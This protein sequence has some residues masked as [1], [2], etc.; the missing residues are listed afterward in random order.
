MSDGLQLV[1]KALEVIHSPQSSNADRL[2]AQ[3]H[4]DQLS[5][6]RNAACYFG[7]ELAKQD[8]DIVRHFGLNLLSNSITKEWHNFSTA[9]RDQI[10]QWVLMLCQ[11]C[12]RETGETHYI[13]EKLA[14]LLNDIAKREWLLTWGDFDGTLQRLWQT[15]HTTRLVCLKTLN[16]LIEDVFLHDDPI[17]ALRSPILSAGVM[18]LMAPADVVAEFYANNPTSLVHGI[19]QKPGSKGWL[20]VLVEQLLQDSEDQAL[21]ILQ[22][23]RSALGWIITKAI[24]VSNTMSAVCQALMNPNV[25]ISTCAVD[26]LYVLLTRP[27][28]PHDDFMQEI[29]TLYKPESLQ[30]L[31]EVWRRTAGSLQFRHLDNAGTLQNEEAYTLLKKLSETIVALACFKFGSSR[32]KK[33]EEIELAHVLDLVL[34]T[35][36]HKSLI[37]SGM[38]H[39]FWCSLLRDEKLSNHPDVLSRFPQMLQIGTQRL[40]RFDDAKTI[41]LAHSE[42][43]MFLDIDMESPLELHEFCINYRRFVYDIVRM[44]VYKRPRDALL[45]VREQVKHFF[46]EEYADTNVGSFCT[47]T[48]PMYL[49]VDAK[50]TMIEAAIQGIIRWQD[51][52]VP[53]TNPM[54]DLNGDATPEARAAAYMELQ[55]MKRAEVA[56]TREIVVAWCA[57]LIELNIQ[58]PLMLGRH[59]SVLVAFASFLDDRSDLLFR[60]LEK[61]IQTITHFYPIDVAETTMVSIRELRGR[62]GTDI[63]R[64]ASALPDQLWTIY[65]QLEATVDKILSAEHVSENDQTTFNAL[66]LIIS[67]RASATEPTEKQAHFE[68][69][70]NKVCSAWDN[71]E[72]TGALANFES[73]AQV[74]QVE[75]VTMYFQSRQVRLPRQLDST[76]LDTQGKAVLQD[77]KDGSRWS[78]PIRASRKFVDATLD[79]PSA[80]RDFEKQLWHR[81][82]VHMVPNLIRL[83]SRINEYYNPSNWKSLPI[84]MQLIA[85]E[86][87]IERFW[88]HGVS[89]VSRD[90]FLESSAKTSD[91]CREL[92]HH[93]GHFLRKTR[94][95]CLVTLGT[96]S[97]LGPAFYD[98]PDL[99]DAC[100]QAF[101]GD[102]SGTSLHVWATTITS[103]LRHLLLNC[104]R[105]QYESFLGKIMVP[106]PQM[107]LQKLQAE[108][109]KLMERGALQSKEEEGTQQEKDD[110]SDEMM[111]ESL[112][113]HLSFAVVKLL[114]DLLA[115]PMLTLRADPNAAGGTAPAGS[116]RTSPLSEWLLRQENMVGGIVL[117][118]C[119]CL[120]INDTRTSVQAAKV[121]RSI[122][123]LL[124]EKND[125]QRYVCHEV[126]SATIRCI[127]DPYFVA[128]QGELVNLLAHIYYLSLGKSTLPRNI[129]LSIPQMSGDVGAVKVF[130]EKLANGKSDRTRRSLMLELLMNH[131]VVGREAY[132]RGATMVKPGADVSTKE[133]IKKFQESVTLKNGNAGNDVLSKDQESGIDRLFD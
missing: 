6:D 107:M 123:P 91:T 41:M 95:Y 66:L 100:M 26:S 79:T 96:Y 90:E 51:R 47:R 10:R 55:S 121:L 54:K 113:R 83:L 97:L 131:D 109:A 50:C 132:G 21:A 39:N 98:I 4:I 40:V 88:L 85:Q 71:N 1:V 2:S 115:P 15:N 118:L 56:S 93:I 114:S 57:E 105:N 99:G 34:M 52:W 68:K 112:L 133:I 59:I 25:K 70:V 42:L 43:Q 27:L 125:L 48:S 16:N 78:W 80:L 72:V 17:A 14:A 44:V 86:S 35:W 110:Y 5:G 53:A 58:D 102:T 103:C 19:A 104:P 73:F 9:E 32:D 31:T 37:I 69:I 23:L 126:F 128:G 13:V 29:Y 18:T 12:V 76:Q 33:L 24:I 36:Q 3:K 84:E 75:K 20:Q 8:K 82:I 116:I 89:Q 94:E 77:L 108:W 111:E 120:T 64:L 11:E 101:F 81:P 124:M 122:V 117:L 46:A 49:N 65:P 28:H 30:A 67:Q 92:A 74:L 62:C 119:F 7:F 45:W 87:I 38:S 106:F 130:E 127:H 22:V 60:I 129:I 61:I 63:L